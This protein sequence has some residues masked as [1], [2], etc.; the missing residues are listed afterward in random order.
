MTKAGSLAP[1][2]GW[3][4]A[5]QWVL[6]LNDESIREQRE[7]FLA[8]SRATILERRAELCDEMNELDDATNDDLLD[9]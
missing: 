2:D 1:L 9:T 5:L 3:Y 7:K 6:N 4:L 8:R